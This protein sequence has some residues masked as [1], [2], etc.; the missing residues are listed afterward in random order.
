[1]GKGERESTGNRKGGAT[2]KEMAGEEREG[3]REKMDKVEEK[4]QGDTVYVIRGDRI[5]VGVVSCL[6]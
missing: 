4:R 2:E 1:M 6:D 3:R 5:A